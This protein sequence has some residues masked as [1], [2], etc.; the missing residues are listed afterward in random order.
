MCENRR[1]C[2]YNELPVQYVLYKDH[3]VQN[4]MKMMMVTKKDIDI[5][6]AIQGYWCGTAFCSPRGHNCPGLVLHGVVAS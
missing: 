3:D 2:P 5:I 1:L 4:R 6:V